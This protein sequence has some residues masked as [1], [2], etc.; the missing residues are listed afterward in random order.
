M[1]KSLTLSMSL[2]LA[3]GFTGVAFAG[4]GGCDTCGLASPQG[5][6]QASAQGYTETCDTCTTKKK[7]CFSLP[8]FSMP[9]CLKPKPKVYTYEWVLKKKKVHG[10]AAAACDTCGT[11]VTPSAQ[12]SSP[13][14]HAAP[15]SWAAP[16]T[17]SVMPTYE[18]KPPVP[19]GDTAPPAPA[20][21]A[22]IPPAPPA[23]APS[24]AQGSLLF[25]APTG[26]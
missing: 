24:A 23:P 14:A 7:H 4:H 11:A 5:S 12:Y 1:L 17:A 6:P 25:L 2:A 26:N 22:T 16:Q 19:T 8:K 18:M 10:H 20:A 15:Q 3:L 9:A 21:P 13:Q